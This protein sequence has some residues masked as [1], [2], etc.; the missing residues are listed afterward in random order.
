MVCCGA[1]RMKLSDQLRD[2]VL[3]GGMTR[4]E[5]SQRSNGLLSQS[6]LCSFVKG[7][8]GLSLRKLDVLAGVLQLEVRRSR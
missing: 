3:S 7:R 5:I 4:Y 8:Q 6:E 1:T 2:L